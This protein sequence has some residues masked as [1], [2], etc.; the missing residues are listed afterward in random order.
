MECGGY[1]IVSGPQIRS[2]P[3]GPSTRRKG[4]SPL[5]PSGDTFRDGSRRGLRPTQA[6]RGRAGGCLSYRD[7]DTPQSHQRA[8]SCCPTHSHSQ[9][10]ARQ[11]LTLLGRGHKL[12]SAAG[13]EDILG[14]ELPTR[15]ENSFAARVLLRG[16]RALFTSEVNAQNPRGR[17]GLGAVWCSDHLPWVRPSRA[18]VGAPPLLF[19]AWPCVPHARTPHSVTHAVDREPEPCL[20]TGLSWLAPAVS[21]FPAAGSPP[22]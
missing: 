7:Q 21:R 15:P 1:T 11:P 18:P 6:S 12:L 8:C 9:A 17:A 5:R 16:R 3:L 4:K 14:R 13:Q 2:R 19:A 22:L 20:R 10:V